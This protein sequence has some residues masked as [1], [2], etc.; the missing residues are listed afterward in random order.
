[1][2]LNTA[3]EQ[4]IVMQKH[5]LDSGEFVCP[6]VEKLVSFINELFEITKQS[7]EFDLNKIK[8]FSLVKRSDVYTILINFIG[9]WSRLNN[10][11]TNFKQFE[12]IYSELQ[13]AFNV[14]LVQHADFI[15]ITNVF[16]VKKA[17][18]CLV[19]NFAN[20]EFVQLCVPVLSKIVN[21]LKEA[22]TDVEITYVQRSVIKD[23][24]NTVSKIPIKIMELLQDQIRETFC[25]DHDLQVK[26]NTT[27]ATIQLPTKLI[28][29][30][31][32]N[33]QIIS[34]NL[35]KVDFEDNESMVNFL[36]AYFENQL[37]TNVKP[38]YIVNQQ[39]KQKF[40]I[41][42][43]S[44][45][46]FVKNMCIIAQQFD[47]KQDYQFL[48]LFMEQ[49]INKYTTQ[50]KNFDQNS[51]L[52][53][54][55]TS[56]LISDNQ[57]L[58]D[59]LKII[60]FAYHVKPI[61]LNLKRLIIQVINLSFRFDSII[62]QYND[63]IGEIQIMLETLLDELESISIKQFVIQEFF[64][65]L[66]VGIMIN[67][68]RIITYDNINEVSEDIYRWQQIFYDYSSDQSKQLEKFITLYSS[69]TYWKQFIQRKIL[70]KST[71]IKIY[72]KYLGSRAEKQQIYKLLQSMK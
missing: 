38:K 2:M 13:S 15:I 36:K 12:D 41:Y 55:I 64:A 29:S 10:V 53:L 45:V 3:I 31:S 5:Q 1:M 50:L 71:L 72:R 58:I 40:P 11:L 16:I 20:S 47:I 19:Q 56:F 52:Q 18:Q 8:S 68:S 30:D 35:A 6:N 39:T 54:K 49:Q 62:Q 51:I 66:S 26:L 65:Q 22:F 9:S 42:I 4:D 57:E 46:D 25:A 14:Q 37:K 59:I 44:I 7:L 69:L 70:P 34:E 23:I 33:Y 63:T 60:F 43:I 61:H 32:C 17:E 27:Y 24:V 28:G 48:L 67:Y 21:Q